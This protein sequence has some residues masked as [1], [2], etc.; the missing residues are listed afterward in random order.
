MIFLFLNVYVGFKLRLIDK[1]FIPTDCVNSFSY[2]V[3]NSI[4]DFEF[5]G[6]EEDVKALEVN[7]NFKKWHLLDFIRN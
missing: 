6:A 3:L 4:A 5:V 2:W 1:E 7:I